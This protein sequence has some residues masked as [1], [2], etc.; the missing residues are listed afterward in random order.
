MNRRQFIKRAVSGLGV[1]ASLPLLLAGKKPK[2]I[3]DEAWLAMQSPAKGRKHLSPFP[4][5][6]NS[7]EY[8]QLQVPLHTGKYGRK[9][10]KNFAVGE[11]R[12][13]G[14]EESMD[15]D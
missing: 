2:P 12:I 13:E 10:L 14:H 9:P 3:G 4:T 1:I 11:D 5:P 8:F 6:L 15:N 7:P